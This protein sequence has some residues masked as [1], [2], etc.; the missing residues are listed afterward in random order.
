[1]G[2]GSEDAESLN[3]EEGGIQGMLLTDSVGRKGRCT[4]S[5]SHVWVIRY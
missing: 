3:G 2:T 4:F 5:F 1:M